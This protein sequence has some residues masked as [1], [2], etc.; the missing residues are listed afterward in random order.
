MRLKGLIEPLITSDKFSSIKSD[1][2]EKDN[3]VEISGLSE[4][5]KAYAVKLH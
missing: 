1:I 4:S 2:E 3:L 5:S